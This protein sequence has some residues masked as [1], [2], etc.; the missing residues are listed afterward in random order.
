VSDSS[1]TPLLLALDTTGEFG[2]LA[3][4]QGGCLVE[5]VGLRSPDGFA[6]ILFG[7]IS[8]LLAR[9]GRA[10]QDLDAIA[11]ASGPGSFTGVR[12][13]LTAAK[14]LA[15]ALAKPV[16]AVSNLQAQAWFGTRPLRAPVMDARR[17]QVFGAVYDDTLGPVQPEVVIALPDWLG[18]LPEGDLEVITNRFAIPP[19]RYAGTITRLDAGGAP[20]PLA[21][22]VAAIA[23]KNLAAGLGQDPQEIDANYVRL[24]DAELLWRDPGLPGGP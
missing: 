12:V 6:H 19:D 2:S 13:C 5:E 20:R 22:A 17:G 21:Q 18:A 16:L 15:E 1:R 9:H 8:A 24:S 10:L 14:G 4:A 23:A 7:E 11:A 3:L